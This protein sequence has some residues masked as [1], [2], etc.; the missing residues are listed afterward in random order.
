MYIHAET[1]IRILDTLMQSFESRIENAIHKTRN[2]NPN[3]NSNS[4]NTACAMAYIYNIIIIILFLNN[5]SKVLLLQTTISLNT[6]TY[7]C[8][9]LTVLEN[10]H[11]DS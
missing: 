1:R 2:P 4:S 7:C 9:T 6:E 8:L 3:W 5:H 11:S 10:A